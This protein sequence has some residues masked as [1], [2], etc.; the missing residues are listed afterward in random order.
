MATGECKHA[1][2]RYVLKKQGNA[3]LKSAGTTPHSHRE[4][5]LHRDGA[6]DTKCPS[7]TRCAHLLGLQQKQLPLI[8]AQGLKHAPRPRARAALIPT[9][10]PN[11]TTAASAAAARG[12]HRRPALR[13]ASREERRTGPRDPGGSGPCAATRRGSG[14]GCTHRRSHPHPRRPR[15]W[16]RRPCLHLS[17]TLHPGPGPGPGPGASLRC[18]PSGALHG[19][20]RGPGLALRVQ[21]PH[22]G[23]GGVVVQLLLLLPG[24]RQLPH[25]QPDSHG[26]AK[27]LQVDALVA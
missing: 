7:L 24:P 9:H 22:V 1:R 10:S 21:Q 4:R 26:H 2:G 19:G 20:G 12:N 8:L 17:T 27:F 3:A 13:S 6:A 25:G 15:R 5:Q 16:R 14:D 23:G 11:T 18:A